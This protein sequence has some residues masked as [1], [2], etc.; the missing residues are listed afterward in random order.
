MIEVM[1]IKRHGLLKGGSSIFETK[2]NLM[3]C[4]CTP[5]TNECC[6]VLVL[7]FYLYLVISW[8]TIHEREGLATCTFINDLVDE[9]CGKIIFGTSLFQIMEVGTYTN[10]ALFFI[11]RHGVWHPLRQ[12]YG[13]DETDFQQFLY[14]ILN[15]C[16]FSR[17]HQ[18][19]LLLDRLSI[20]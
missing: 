11:D 15:S 3:I 1:E 10:R 2:R 20:G 17:I 9:Q 4:E 16:L 18:I 19:K 12:L 14:F 5:W 6:F 8:K 7:G 13:V